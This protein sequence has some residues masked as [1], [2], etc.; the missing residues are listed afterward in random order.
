MLRIEEKG[1]NSW[2]VVNYED[3]PFTQLL[4]RENVREQAR[5][6]LLVEGFEYSL[7]IQIFE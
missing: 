4:C 6:K 5:W 7:I 3:E 1:R 2:Y